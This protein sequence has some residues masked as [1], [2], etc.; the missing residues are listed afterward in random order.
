L[1]CKYSDRG[2]NYYSSTEI[3]AKPFCSNQ[4]GFLHSNQDDARAI[5]QQF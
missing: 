2:S 5:T 4:K 1:T 3:I